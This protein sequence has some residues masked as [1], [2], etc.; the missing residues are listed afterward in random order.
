[1]SLTQVLKVTTKKYQ[2]DPKVY[3]G[4]GM[5]NILTIKPW[6]YV[7]AIPAVLASI[8]FLLPGTIW[9]IAFAIVLYFLRIDFQ[10]SAKDKMLYENQKINICI[11][12]TL[13]VHYFILVIYD[14]QYIQSIS[15]SVIYGFLKTILTQTFLHFY[16]LSIL[17]FTFTIYKKQI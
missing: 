17:L 3:I 9:W 11:F 16:Q 14:I 1:M 7:H 6:V 12:W 2:L 15:A 13:F 10:F 8:A 4:L 5:N